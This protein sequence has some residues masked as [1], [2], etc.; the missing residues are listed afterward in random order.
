[1]IASLAES[2]DPLCDEVSSGLSYRMSL[3]AILRS[4]LKLPFKFTISWHALLLTLL[5]QPDFKAA[6]AVAYCDTYR[7]VAREYARG[8]GVVER[9][10]FTLSVQFLNR[11]KFCQDL[12]MERN[13][14]SKLSKSLLE[15]MSIASFFPGSTGSPTPAG[16]SPDT[17]VQLSSLR[18]N[19][20]NFAAILMALFGSFDVPGDNNFILMEL[21]S[22]LD[23]L[24]NLDGN[25]VGGDSRHHGRSSIPPPVAEESPRQ[26]DT[27]VSIDSLIKRTQALVNPTLNPTHPFLQHRRYSPC[28]SDLKCVLNVKGMSRIFLSIPNATEDKLLSTESDGVAIDNWIQVRFK[29]FGSGYIYGLSARFTSSSPQQTLSLAQNMDGQMWRSFNLGHV[30]SEHRGWVGA[31]NTSI[32]LGSVFERLLN[33]EGV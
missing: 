28:I 13:L 18:T 33:W 26:R 22:E 4:D 25:G 31:F 5:S 23:N 11:A 21:D 24:I 3:N 6:L 20:S 2:C 12:V 7:A 10:S 9:S 14:L 27:V 17:L 30:E 8:V 32:S 15:T 19:P 16:A 1:M 29:C